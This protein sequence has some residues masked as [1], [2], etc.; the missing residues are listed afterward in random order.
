MKRERKKNHK[1][2]VL[3]NSDFENLNWN[4]LLGCYI[5]VMS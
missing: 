4:D 1:P 2:L 5:H 3:S